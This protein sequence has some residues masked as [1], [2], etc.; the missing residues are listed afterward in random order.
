MISK[1]LSTL[2]LGQL[3]VFSSVEPCTRIFWNDNDQARL[4][5]RT[6]DLFI[7]DEPQ[8]WVHPRGLHHESLIDENGLKWDSFYGNV[9]ISAF[10]HKDVI[11]DGMN[12]QGFAA[13]VLALRATQYEKRDDR[14]G[15]HYGEWVQYLL[16]T[17]QTVEE[18]VAAHQRFQVLPTAINNFV[19]PLHLMLED[20]TGDSA[21][22]EFVEGKMQ[23]YH[24]RHYRIGTNDPVYD[25]QLKNWSHFEEGTP[26][27]SGA[28][29]VSRFIRAS[30]YLNHLPKPENS[31]AAITS[32][33]NAIT[34]VFQNNQIPVNFMGK[35]HRV[36]TFWT[37]IQDLTHRKYYFFP[38]NQKEGLLIDF[39]KMDFEGPASE[40]MNLLNPSI[41][42]KDQNL[43][44]PCLKNR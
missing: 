27:P 6:M 25:Q 13:H 26:L 20:A 40:V 29:A 28:D 30:S 2:M 16:D 9:V 41:S 11:T 22:I 4:V 32:L 38:T 35:I 3:L 1:L 39:A 36:T 18:A 21:I 44:A 5:A 31:D 37:V 10:H 8:M 12:E 42:E 17:C 33:K 14:P 15:I 24:D 34:Q 43:C 23:V 19:W 7:S